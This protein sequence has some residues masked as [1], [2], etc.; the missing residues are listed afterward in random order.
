MNSIVNFLL[1]SGI[2]LA[3]YVTIYILFLRRETYF[4]LNR[5]YLLGSI[6]FSILLPFINIQVYSSQPQMLP[7]ITVTPF[8]NLFEAVVVY[9][10]DFTN[11]IEQTVLSLSL[12][13]WIYITGLILYLGRILLNTVQ[14]WRIIKKY[15]IKRHP[16]IKVVL[17]DQNYGPF[18]F[19]NYVFIQQSH[20]DNTAEIEGIFTHEAEHVKQ[21]HTFDILFLELITALQWFNPFVWLLR[22]VVR[23]NHEFLADQAVLES[24]MN[25]GLYK[26]QLLIQF[27]GG[28]LV[29]TNN[30][31]Y[32]IIK[33]RIK[34]MSKTKSTGKAT[35]K[36]VLGFITVIALVMIFACEQKEMEEIILPDAEEKPNMVPKF[37]NPDENIFFI[38]ENMPEFPG[39]ELALRQF[40]AS[41]INY[42]EEAI[43]YSIQ[44]RVYVSFVVD[45]TGNVANARIVRGID[46][47]LD[48][49]A[50][51][52]V[53]SLPKWKPG[54]QRDKPVN[55]AYTVPIS[56][57]LQ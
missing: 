6:F 5:L 51:R 43:K 17:T 23:E 19:F 11:N 37:L 2:C 31:N 25:R 4:K 1:E 13:L 21:G 39:G 18:S 26:K 44:G 27:L 40:I 32:S 47:L 29:I 9:G 55:V 33:K 12:L 3:L 54:M 15:P 48:K 38:V 28:Q 8:L 42:P 49:E 34:M 16:G 46:P 30:F 57:A 20:Y 50:L 14:L 45:K 7:E 52:V 35:V 10:H 22:Q 41:T 53:N 36:S 24:G 56:F